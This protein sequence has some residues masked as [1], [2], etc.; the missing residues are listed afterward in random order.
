MVK[1]SLTPKSQSRKKSKAHTQ[2]AF[3]DDLASAPVAAIGDV[4]EEEAN[5][6]KPRKTRN[7]KG[8]TR[9]K[10]KRIKKDKGVRMVKVNGQWKS[11][12]NVC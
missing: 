8:Q 11:I 6:S 7:D 12:E 10:I 3:V 5:V 1:R 9:M 4:E 2:L